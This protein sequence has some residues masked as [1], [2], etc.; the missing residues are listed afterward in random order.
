MKV[1]VKAEGKVQKSQ[2]R[3]PKA[4]QPKAGQA[5]SSRQT[6]SR[7]KSGQT[8]DRSIEQE[9][10]RIMPKGVSPKTASER[11]GPEQVGQTQRQARPDQRSA[12]GGQQTARRGAR[13]ARPQ[14]RAEEEHTPSSFRLFYALRV[15]SEVAAR[16]AEAQRG[17]K[18][19]W[20]AVRADQLHVTLA[21]LPAAPPERLADLKALGARLIPELP[22][23]AVRLRGT[24]Y[25]PNEGSPRVW[26]VKVEA[27]GLNELAAALRAGI[28]ELGLSTDDLAFKAH[29][30]LARKKGPAP[31]VPPQTYDLG[32]IAGGVTLYRSFLQK[33]G[34][35][36]EPQSTFRFRTPEVATS[37]PDAPE[38][39]P[40]PE[41]APPQE[42]S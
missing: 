32:W 13:P 12:K 16:L 17:L 6:S 34:P 21:Y 29:I 36:Y 42:P 25:F 26:F 11:V 8:A 35:I 37:P 7:P 33:T 28:Q 38:A 27:E 40:A 1:R 41:S 10:A 22:P 3:R 9:V 4:E 23:L 39:T 15:P 14:P 5:Q 20:R 30:T 2:G 31:R 19:N 24:G 18:G